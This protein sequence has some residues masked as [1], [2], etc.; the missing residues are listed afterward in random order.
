M[1]S[2]F[3]GAIAV[4]QTKGQVAVVEET[5]HLRG[6]VRKAWVSLSGYRAEFVAD[7]NHVKLLKVNTKVKIVQDSQIAMTGANVI[8]SG[9]LYLRD[10]GNDDTF[11]GSIYYT[12]FVDYTPVTTL[13]Q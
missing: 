7:D 8:V 6:Q 5:T 2:I 10:K 4:P 1:I 13:N 3:N 9:E 12:L 11:N